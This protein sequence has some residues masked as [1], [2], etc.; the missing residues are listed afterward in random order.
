MNENGPSE[1][2]GTLEGRAPELFSRAGIE[3][4]PFG[5]PQPIDEDVYLVRVPLPNNPL[6]A[7][8]S[9][10]ILGPDTTTIVDVGFNH[11]DCLRALDDAL[12][13]LGRT[14]EGV[15]ILLTHSHPDHCGCVDLAWRAGMPV[16]AN[17]G[18]FEE[19]ETLK[20]AWLG[21]LRLMLPAVSVPNLPRREAPLELLHPRVRPAITRIAEGD[22]V[23]EG[24]LRLVVRETPGHDSWHVCLHEPDRRLAIVGDHVLKRI[25][26]AVNALDAEHDVLG[27]F[28]GSLRA[29]RDLDAIVVLPAHG[30]LYTDLA[31]RVDELLAHHAARLDE[32]QGLVEAGHAD[33]V[34]I[35][36]HAKWRYDDWDAW[37]PAQKMSSISETMAH[38][39]HLEKLGRVRIVRTGE[40][41]RFEAVRR[42]WK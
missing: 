18:S 33:L 6:V 20:N 22:E 41:Y 3:A 39:V 40:G 37:D 35:A 21:Q 1:G 14:W 15:R 19:L 29:V 4:I 26:P 42:P 11:P 36:S 38:L 5:A 7:L 30:S 8:N 12:R 31:G 10:F 34:G 13:A 28:L 27:E 9:Y 16:L 32:L 23:R 24:N 2:A 25:T 17:F